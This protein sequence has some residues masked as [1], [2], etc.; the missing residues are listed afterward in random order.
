MRELLA[1]LQKGTAAG[2]G[3]GRQCLNTESAALREWSQRVP[4]VEEKLLAYRALAEELSAVPI[5]VLPYGL[6]K[7]FDTTG[8]RELFQRAYFER[9]KRLDVMAVLTIADGGEQY[10]NGLEDIVWAICDEY[11]WSLPAHLGNSLHYDATHRTTIDLFAAETAYTLAEIMHLAGD[12]LS[13]IVA[14]R[15]RAEIKSRVLEPYVSSTPAAWWESSDMNWAAV[16]GGSVGM[17]A[18]YL[19]KDDAELLPIVQRTLSTMDGYIAG[20]ADDGA[21][22]EGLG[23]WNYGFVYYCAY[24]ELLRQRTA[25]GIRLME[26]DKIRK[27]AKFQQ[28]CYLDGSRTISYSD[29]SDTYEYQPGLTHY[30]K[31][32]DPDID[33]PDRACEAGLF[34]DNCF[35]WIHVYRNLVWIDPNAEATG[36]PDTDYWLDQAQIVVSRQT[37]KGRT[38]AFS[39]KGGANN[40]PH[41]HN[42][43]GSFIYYA[44]GEQLLADPGRGVYSKVYFGSDRYRM[45]YNGS[46]GHSVPIVEGMYQ[47]EGAMHRG[48]VLDVDISDDTVEI[49]MELVN[50]YACPNLVALAR[51]LR[52]DKRTGE[53]RLQDRFEFAVQPADYRERFVTFR[54]PVIH[55]DGS[56]FIRGC[57]DIGLRLRYDVGRLRPEL[58]SEPFLPGVLGKETLHLIDLVPVSPIKADTIEVVMTLE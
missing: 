18:M 54:E 36:L 32:H 23:Y 42:D 48:Q 16:C 21:C 43:V 13:P 24:A 15:A 29:S 9:R 20:F 27:I 39:A 25:G 14:D 11:A 7:L 35:R 22:L 17:A 55:S 40:E 19:L 56:L 46:H 30:L 2:G 50:A 41:N 6:Y 5:E 34:G 37:V 44:G 26:R 3:D 31:R 47:R 49:A 52:F 38:V 1:A 33:I 51:R 57:A 8:D 4:A 12:R 28:Q 45:I 53:L 10:V 58:V